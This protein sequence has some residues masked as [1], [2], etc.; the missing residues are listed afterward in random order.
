MEDTKA[1]P[2]RKPVQLGDPAKGGLLY[3]KV[4]LREPTAGE[5]E[6]SSN[7]TNNVGVTIT[8]IS[9]VANL[10]RGVVERFSQR[11]LQACNDFL[12][13]FGNGSPETGETDS[14]S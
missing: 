8:L 1:I 2:L 14:P 11:D 10:P 13:T 6:K 12:A 3:D 9:L 7:A 5:L 4:E